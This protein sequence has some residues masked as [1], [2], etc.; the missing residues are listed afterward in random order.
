M[1]SVSTMTLITSLRL[2]VLRLVDWLSRKW[3]GMIGALLA[4][5]L[6]AFS[7]PPFGQSW[8]ALIAALL[9][10][11]TVCTAPPARAFLLGT[12]FGLTCFGLGVSWVYV[13]IHVYGN[14]PPILAAFLTGLFVL[15]LALIL[16]ATQML[17]YRLLSPRSDALV[18]ALVWVVW[19]WL[20]TWI[21][22]GFPW[23]LTGHMLIDTPFGGFAPVGGVLLV[24]LTALLAALALWPA[25]IQLRLRPL[26]LLFGLPALGF[27]LSHVPWV[28]DRGESLQVALVQGN[29]PQE[30]KWLPENAVHVLNTHADL[31]EPHWSGADIIVWP[32]AAITTPLE[33][34]GPLLKA[35]Q[36]RAAPGGSTLISGI[37]S[38]QREAEQWHTYNT[39]IAVGE[40]DGRYVKR[41]LVP[42]GEYVPLEG[43]LRGLIEFFDLPRSRSRPGPPAQPNLV[44][45]GHN[46]A[47][48]I[49]YEIVYPELVREAAR[50]AD[51]LLTI[52]NDTWFGRS[53]GPLQ[54]MHIARIRALEHGR[55]L[56]RGTNNGVTAI[57]DERGRILDQLPRFT[58]DVL[59]GEARLFTGRTPF[60]RYGF[61][62]WL[63]VISVWIAAACALGREFR[64]AP[65][66]HARSR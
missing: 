15:G 52:S 33:S 16:P 21:F 8:L 9:L 43:W 7:M 44:A 65:S 48:A 32:E 41:H 56:L 55:Y 23:M 30:T 37:L 38:Y 26:V 17:C 40:G 27:A 39:A 24:S 66:S 4:G 10:F 11:F 19:E 53:S 14:A 60:S 64:G 1:R 34:A 36:L 13:S 42:F 5:A 25:L 58:A 22:T 46:I 63:V 2:L 51:L 45:Q 35:L 62:P 50:T 12:C 47:V 59:V 3:P 61:W 49:C 6:M 57:V 18:F 31:S 20:S 29:I 28:Q 54:H